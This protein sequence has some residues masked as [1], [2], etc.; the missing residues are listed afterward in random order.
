MTRQAFQPQPSSL[1][2]SLDSVCLVTCRKTPDQRR[3]RG[4]SFSMP[5]TLLKVQTRCCPKGSWH[6]AAY[7]GH[8]WLSKALIV[9]YRLHLMLHG[10]SL[11]TEKRSALAIL[12]AQLS[13]LAAYEKMPPTALHVI[14]QHNA[15]VAR[16]VKGSIKDAYCSHGPK[17][18]TTCATAGTDD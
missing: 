15:F 16:S 2:H 14:Q 18:R 9:S 3:T 17:Q 8:G 11:V 10:H 4:A 13:E 1:L 6:K 7:Y 5:Q 12:H